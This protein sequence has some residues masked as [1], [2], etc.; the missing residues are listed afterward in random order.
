MEVI[1]NDTARDHD[2][3]KIDTFT[4]EI[5][6]DEMTRNKRN[7]EIASKA[8]S[9]V[10]AHAQAQ[11]PPGRQGRVCV[12][13]SPGKFLPVFMGKLSSELL[14]AIISNDAYT[15]QKMRLS[16]ASHIAYC[17]LY[18]WGGERPGA[19]GGFGIISF[20]CG[21]AAGGGDRSGENNEA[22]FIPTQRSPS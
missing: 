9:M 7:K 22:D 5:L 17:I 20:N 19:P 3:C 13:D 4:V 8:H 14:P 15:N 18:P 16:S 11:P 1:S 2:E 6:G 10:K 12:L 21:G